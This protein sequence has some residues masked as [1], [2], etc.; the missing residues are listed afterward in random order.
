MMKITV[1]VAMDPQQAIGKNQQLPWYLPEDLAFFKQ[2]TLGKPILMGRKTWE[3]LPK[4]PLPGR[5]NLV[6]TRNAFYQAEGAKVFNNYET[7]LSSYGTCPEL[8]VI[9]GAEIFN[10]MLPAATD[11]RIT[12]VHQTIPAADCFFPPISEADWHLVSEKRELSKTGIEFSWQHYVR[13]S[14]A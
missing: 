5:P 13:P 1:V 14:A 2:Y 3:S 9:G 6:L 4:K 10:I 11:L 12:Q 7:A 8:C